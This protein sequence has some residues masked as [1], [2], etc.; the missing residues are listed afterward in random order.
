MLTK[1]QVITRFRN[2][3]AKIILARDELIAID[4]QFGNGNHGITME[5]IAA[6]MLTVMA[7]AEASDMDIKTMLNRI[8]TEIMTLNGGSSVPLWTTLFEGLGKG[9]PHAAELD[10][11][12]LKKMFRSCLDA[13]CD[14]S[15][16][17]VGD[18]T[19][20]DTLIPAV[21]AIIGCPSDD[22]AEILE[23]GMIAAKKGAKSTQNFIAK[24]GS[25]R[26]YKEAT[27][28]AMDAGAM[29]MMC[30]FIGLTKG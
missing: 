3:A 27:L 23:T 16:A 17:R 8:S 11:S 26:D 24:F 10:G 20:M 30:F 7:R 5:K 13:M 28:G 29:S 15:T 2:A 18:K 22:P 1:P 14:L 19:M 4:A 21:E 25:A 12:A 6:S 9:T